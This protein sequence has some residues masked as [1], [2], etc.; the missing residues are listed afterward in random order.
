MNSQRWWSGVILCGVLT[1]CGG[2]GVPVP[3]DRFHRLNV[4]APTTVYATPPLAGIVEVD[5]FRAAGVLH[6][7]AIVFVE[8]DNPN[9][10]HQY[11]YQLWADPPTRML[12]IVTVDY[13]R[14][15]H[16]ANQVVTTGLGI[17]PAYTLTGD[18]KKLEHMVGNSSSV[19]VEIEFGL[20]E[21]SD[22]SLVWVKRYSES[23]TVKDDKVGT[24]TRAIS[25]AVTKILTSLSADLVRQ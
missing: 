8:H 16:L 17:E 13:L 24:A 22:G 6:D 12:Q 11:H 3:T 15:A 10:L 4:G 19:M 9:V 2:Q 20:R 23:M 1:G 14:E 18:I 21:H 25:E 5:R 7:R